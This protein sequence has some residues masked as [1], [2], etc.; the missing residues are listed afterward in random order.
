MRLWAA[1]RAGTAALH[2]DTNFVRR[3]AIEFLSGTHCH[4]ASKVAASPGADT[5]E[6]VDR[7]TIGRIGS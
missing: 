5:N 6:G 7:D 4:T 3:T 1:T 2:R